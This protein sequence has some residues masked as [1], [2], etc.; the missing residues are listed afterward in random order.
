MINNKEIYEFSE[1]KWE[2][3]KLKVLM[4]RRII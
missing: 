2:I 3:T 1:V 4:K